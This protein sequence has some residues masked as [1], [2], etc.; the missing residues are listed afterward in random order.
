MIQEHTTY[1]IRG[2]AFEVH[3][4]LGPGLLE[5]AYQQCL[6]YELS[7]R[8]HLVEREVGLPLKYNNVSLDVGYRID[9]L[10]DRSIILEIKSVEKFLP[11]YTAQL[12][13]YLK[14]SEIRVGLLM[15]FNTQNMQTGI[16]RYV[17]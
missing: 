6:A 8:G 2:A 11:I 5:S 9:L 16:K 10:V 15:N 17:L 4:A 13:T 7:Q 3:R 14:L 1:A 12:L